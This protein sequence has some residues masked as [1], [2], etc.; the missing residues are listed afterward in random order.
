[1]LGLEKRV[2]RIKAM[3]PTS[4]MADIAFLLII[5]FMVAT[6]QTTDRTNVSLPASV[7]RDE[8]L[9]NSVIITATAEGQLKF[10]VGEVPTDVFNLDDLLPLV[11]KEL[12]IDSNRTFVI[13]SDKAVRYDTIDKI[14]SKLRDAQAHNVF[15]LTEQT[16]SRH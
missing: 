8:M 15:F 6:V 13:K 14:L 4:S 12:E 7:V 16:A 5:F 3:V 10:T 1:M 11:R 9:K 2:R